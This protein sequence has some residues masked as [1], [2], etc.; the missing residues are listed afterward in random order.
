LALVTPSHLQK[1]RVAEVKAQFQD[2]IALVQHDLRNAEQR[3]VQADACL[4]EQRREHGQIMAKVEAEGVTEL[5]RQMAALRLECTD[6]VAHAQT[7]TAAARAELTQ[8][9]SDAE[10]TSHQQALESEVKLSGML[11]AHVRSALESTIQSLQAKNR[12]LQ[13]R[14]TI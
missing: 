7:E 14:A 1:A 9:R 5:Q 13:L 4:A 3:A 6:A 10:H 11:P 2:Q 12:A 8:V